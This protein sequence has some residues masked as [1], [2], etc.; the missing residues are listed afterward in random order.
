ME[1][2]KEE[3]YKA[4]SERV[5]FDDDGVPRW[6]VGNRRNI[7]KAGAIAGCTGS[8]YRTIGIRHNGRATSILAHRLI[9]Y[10]EY[11]YLPMGIDHI[12]RNTLNNRIE[13][14]RPC[15]NQLNQY[16]VPKRA[17]LTSKYKGVCWVSAKN[18]WQVSMRIDKAKQYIGVFRDESQAAIAHDEVAL[19]SHGEFAWLNIDNFKELM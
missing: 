1:R 7:V 12:D 6:L 2:V 14:L 16:N 18:Y 15:N 11:G 9:F 17:G 10:M 19:A 8:G 4:L 5:E 13:N 3:V